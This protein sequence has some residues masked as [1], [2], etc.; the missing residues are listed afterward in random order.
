MLKLSS[1]LHDRT[2]GMI[3][4]LSH[5]VREAALDAILDGSERITKASLERV[6]LDENAEQQNLPRARRRRARNE[7]RTA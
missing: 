1:Y 4:S 3:G 2:G 5:L 6:D 7:K